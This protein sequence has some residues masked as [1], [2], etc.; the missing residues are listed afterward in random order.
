MVLQSNCSSD[1]DVISIIDKANTEEKVCLLR[2][3]GIQ[4]E[5]RHD[6]GRTIFNMLSKEASN[7]IG[8]LVRTGKG[9]PYWLIVHNTAKFLKAKSYDQDPNW[10]KRNYHILER[11]IFDMVFRTFLYNIPEN[12]R[13]TLDNDLSFISDKLLRRTDKSDSKVATI[14]SLGLGSTSLLAMIGSSFG[15]TIAPLWLLAIS[16]LTVQRYGASKYKKIIPF[17]SVVASIRL[18]LESCDTYDETYDLQRDK[19]QVRSGF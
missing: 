10:A 4:E 12:K 2:T 3:L 16:A 18:R 17:I 5:N 7:S 9:L 13:D 8:R 14:S 6:A 11:N 15:A 19:I 1:D